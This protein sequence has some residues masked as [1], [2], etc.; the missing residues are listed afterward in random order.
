MTL[1]S[2]PPRE[3]IRKGPGNGPKLTRYPPMP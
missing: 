1:S 2:G 3:R